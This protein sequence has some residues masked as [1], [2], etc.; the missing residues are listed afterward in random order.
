MG[1]AAPLGGCAHDE[2]AIGPK[3]HSLRF[4]GN[5][6][7]S[8]RTLRAKLVTEQTGWWPFAASKRLDVAALDLDVKRVSAFYADQGFFDAR[9]I[10][11]RVVPRAGKS[12]QVD[13]VLK[14][15]EGKPTLIQRVEISGLAD[16]VERRRATDITRSEGVV[17][18][19][20]F[21]Y[22]SYDEARRR[23]VSALQDAGYA[24]V[25]VQGDVAV[26][27]DLHQATVTYRVTSGPVVHFAAT[28]L[29]GAGEI[30]EWKLR[31]RLSWNPGDRYD[32]DHITTT[33]GRLYDLGV[34]STVRIELPPHPTPA[35]EVTVT[36][37]PGK[38]HELRLGAGVGV[39]TLRQEVRL[40]G[41][42]WFSNFLGGLRK[43][44]LQVK[45]AWAVIPSITNPQ[46]S[47]PVA[48]A[49]A[50]LTQPDLF[51][52]SITGQA[53]AGYDLM[54]TEG[55]AA[56]GP[57]GNLGMRRSFWRDRV[58][59]GVSWNLQ[60]LDFYDI[61]TDAFD[62]N[63][64]ALGLGFVDPYRLAYTEEFVQLDLMDRMRA[65]GIGAFG[66]L[67]LEQG[68][69]YLGGQFR[70]LV[71]VPELRV[72]VPLG[73]RVVLAGR[74]MVGG[75]WP[76][77]TAA[78][79]SPVT[80]RFRMGGPASHR[81]FSFG[82]L[83]P[84]IADQNGT[85]IP[86]GGDGQILLSA[87]VRVEIVQVAGGWVSLAPFFDAGD[88]TVHFDNLSLG[89]LH[90]AA[91]LAATYATPIGV[92]RAG[93]ALRLNRLGGTVTPGLPVENPDPGQRFAFHITIGEAF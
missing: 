31:R 17:P 84:Q 60:F 23:I 57:R 19:V 13:V 65:V 72:L 29:V 70:Y 3:V 49:Q 46:R 33:Q 37:S 10:E 80:R 83:A 59:G 26:D 22:G 73:K 4:E 8:A 35:P 68:S 69:P 2:R 56:R 77:G 36:V 91:G 76:A 64:T 66:S 18:G 20:R 75:L 11:K 87:E 92:V 71:A 82:R 28:R 24:Y 6:E 30:P 90:H 43:L 5:D 39:D 51:G 54:L 79:E 42:W 45:P 27:R 74:G 47:G 41:E 53:T 58:L 40:R 52:T 48:E 25:Q 85:P 81:G 88:V 62:P 55:Y 9:V 34:F 63:M 93:A 12:D 44:R 21:E 1:A 67:R 78:S 50:Q 38:L 15:E 89:R 32:P 14:I 61:N 7:F 16:E 86:V